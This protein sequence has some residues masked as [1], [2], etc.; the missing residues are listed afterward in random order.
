MFN[1]QTT[2]Y[3]AALLRK[4]SPTDSAIRTQAVCG[5]GRHNYLEASKFTCAH[6]NV[7]ILLA[8]SI[9][10]SFI[11]LPKFRIIISV[12]NSC[13]PTRSR[14][15]FD[16]LISMCR[17][18]WPVVV[19]PKQQMKQNCRSNVFWC[20]ERAFGTTRVYLS[21]SVSLGGYVYSMYHNPDL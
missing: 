12:L 3:L 6:W 19:V 10:H 1:L 13:F 2:M 7:C 5:G 4:T 21:L 11:V 14:G 8:S 17:V 15:Q 20:R 9:L 18:L 16:H